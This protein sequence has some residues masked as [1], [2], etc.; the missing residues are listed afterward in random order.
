[1]RTIDF[2]SGDERVVGVLHEPPG[3]IKR[4]AVL[5]TH[6]LLSSRLE[7]GNYPELLS[8]RG[9]ITMA[10]DL[11]GHGESTGQRGY[12]SP[13]RGIQD[14][15]SALDCLIGFPGVDPSRLALVGHSL[16]AALSICAAAA[17]PRVRVV[18]A[19]APPA[20]IRHELRPGEGTLYGVAG[21]AGAL[22]KSLTGR[23]L[24]LPYRVGVND[25]FHHESARQAAQQQDF[26]QKTAPHETAGK[27]VKELDTLSCALKVTIPTLVMRGEHDRVVKSSRLVYESLAG[28][29]EFATVHDSGH[30]IMMDAHGAEAFEVVADWLARHL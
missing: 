29:K 25:I 24:Y 20:S 17:D 13:D 8:Q 15:R 21:A 1:M 11:R 7:W 30:S 10:Y 4:P 2:Q 14:I 23:S 28:P 18:I 3:M 27:L 19:I 12:A 22:F 6:G 5:F 26:L 9:Y 16:G